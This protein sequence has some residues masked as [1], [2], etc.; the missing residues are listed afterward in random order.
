MANTAAPAPTIKPQIW[1]VDH[2]GL[3]VLHLS[4]QDPFSVVV[5]VPDTGQHEGEVEVTLE[6]GGQST[7]LSVPFTG[8]GGGIVQ[9]RIENQRLDDDEVLFDSDEHSFWIDNGESITISGLGAEPFRGFAFEVPAA[10]DTAAGLAHLEM[11]F[12]TW[13]GFRHSVSQLPIQ[14]DETRDVMLIAT[15]Y[16]QQL[17]TGM[18]QIRHFLDGD[19]NDKYA[20]ARAVVD[21]MVRETPGDPVASICQGIRP[22]TYTRRPREF[23]DLIR[24]AIAAYEDKVGD[25]FLHTMAVATIASYRAFVQYAGTDTMLTISTSVY[26][27][28]AAWEQGDDDWVQQQGIDEMGQ[29]KSDVA[30]IQDMAI[31]W[32]IGRLIQAGE[33][34]LTGGKE[35]EVLTPTAQP[36]QASVDVDVD[37]PTLPH[38]AE[39]PTPGRI[40]SPEHFGIR[41][42]VLPGVRRI[43]DDHGVVILFRPGNMDSMGWQALGHP[44]KSTEIKTKTLQEVDQYIG[45][46]GKRS[47]GLVGVFEPSLPARP[48][49]ISDVDWDTMVKGGRRPPE[50]TDDV[51]WTEFKNAWADD[52]RRIWGDFV[53][54]GVPPGLG[55]KLIQRFTQRRLEFEDNIASL[56]KLEEQGLIRVE[57][58]LLIDTGLYGG[59]GK[60]IT[61]DYDLFQI[62]GRDGLPVSPAKYRE[63]LEALKADPDHLVVHGA[64]MRWPEDAPFARG[65]KE[66]GIFDAIMTGHE[67]EALL[68]VGGFSDGL[69]R[70]TYVRPIGGGRELITTREGTVIWDG[71]FL[72][73]PSPLEVAAHGGPL[74]LDKV[75]AAG[76]VLR[77][78]KPSHLAFDEQGAAAPPSV[79]SSAG[80]SGEMSAGEKA[81]YRD[82][83]DAK[84]FA[85]LE[86]ED[87]VPEFSGDPSLFGDDDEPERNDVPPAGPDALSDEPWLDDSLSLRPVDD[88]VN[89]QQDGMYAG[90]LAERRVLAQCDRCAPQAHDLSMARTQVTVLEADVARLE[91]LL[92]G[93]ADRA[94]EIEPALHEAGVMLDRARREM[95]IRAFILEECERTC[96]PVLPFDPWR[97][98]A[99]VDDVVPSATAP[100]SAPEVDCC[101]ACREEAVALRFAQSRLNTLRFA[102]P[103]GADR[104]YDLAIERARRQYEEARIRLNLCTYLLCTDDFSQLYASELGRPPGYEQYER[105][106]D[107][108]ECQQICRMLAA[109][110]GLADY[111]AQRALDEGVTAAGASSMATA[112]R[113]RGTAAYLEDLLERCERERCAGGHSATAS[114]LMI[115]PADSTIHAGPASPVPVTPSTPASTKKLMWWL[116]SFGAGAIGIALFFGLSGGSNGATV[117]DAAPSGAQV[118][119]ADGA[120][121]PAPPTPEVQP[122]PAPAPVAEPPAA[123][124]P[125]EQPPPIVDGSPEVIRKIA[126]PIGSSIRVVRDAAGGLSWSIVDAD[127]KPLDSTE[128]LEYFAFVAFFPQEVL[129][130]FGNASSYPCGGVTDEYRV[131]CPLGAGLLSE[132]EYIVV[133]ARLAGPIG[134]GAQSFTYGLAFDDDGDDSDNYQFVAPFNADFFRNTEYWYRLDIDTDG[135]RTMW[136]DGARDGVLGY[137]RFSSAM[138]IESDD[139][140][141]WIIPRDEVPGEQLAYR[142]TAFHNDGDP[143]A[144]PVPES[145]GGDVSGF[146]VDEPLTPIPLDPIMFDNV[147]GLPPDIDDPIPRVQVTGDPDTVITLVLVEEF[148]NRLNTALAAGDVEAVIATV[149]PGLLSGPKAAE[150][151]QAIETTVALADSVEVAA[152]SAPPDVSIGTPIYGATATISYPTGTVAW[153]PVLTPGPQGRLYLLLPS[154]V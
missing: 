129:D 56:R 145:S 82:E 153:G 45:G 131:T 137:P 57:D 25:Q 43:A 72:M 58:G 116:A 50:M 67:H 14:N 79:S 33:T 75:L 119:V 104:A 42:E 44:A 98:P 81:R 53:P 41:E 2:E 38:G 132:G 39:A 68:M 93:H 5:V 15:R 6:V 112:E 37:T 133:G 22:Y 91:A 154:C 95:S 106:S 147:A 99:D 18:G 125:V 134:E 8:R 60:A 117:D 52:V 34:H 30:L 12:E 108:P 87:L 54:P 29:A 144:V 36:K 107:C 128:L 94:V 110:L 143:A 92:D 84:K 28:Y 78:I 127:G 148:A 65:S 73:R 13:L 61:G 17:S 83:Q 66:E 71:G 23:S 124:N 7:T 27:K 64:H 101:E 126:G 4:K 140:L 9:H 97:E 90:L 59:T 152:S 113:C 89:F 69:V 31:E 40:V 24:N 130:P 35:L 48:P 49:N 46:P 150:C 149:H 88:P 96:E 102:R 123:A 16:L 20:R 142:V 51:E 26:A 74:T 21:L 47:T 3:P 100:L 76:S 139:T 10:R 115:E 109:N 114:T 62:V 19:R 85:E 77:R 136:A 55:D 141:V 63:V 105:V 70:T 122:T 121:A 11:V 138:V 135:N 111:W 32:V 120:P 1:I 103:P 151:R 80:S 86:R 118:V 146:G